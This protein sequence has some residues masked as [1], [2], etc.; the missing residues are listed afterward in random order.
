MD[1]EIIEKIKRIDKA[2]MNSNSME[3]EF[4]DNNPYNLL[5]IYIFKNGHKGLENIHDG[6]FLEYNPKSESYIN[7]SFIYDS[8]IGGE[9]DDISTLD[10]L[11]DEN[12][13]LISDDLQIGEENGK[14]HIYGYKMNTIVE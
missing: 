1:K 8:D 4:L 9:V 6:F 14:V 11:L 5:R 12:D 2:V 3:I 13:S 10:N 7:H